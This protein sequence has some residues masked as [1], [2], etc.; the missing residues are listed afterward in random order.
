MIHYG[1]RLKAGM[2]RVGISNFVTFLENTAEYRRD[3]R[4]QEYGDERDPNMRG[5][6]IK[7]SPTTSAHKINKPMFIAQGL[8]DPRVPANESE[9]IVASARNSGVDV[10]YM[11]AKDEGH[12][13]SKKKNI[14][15]CY[16]HNWR[17]YLRFNGTSVAADGCAKRLLLQ[18]YH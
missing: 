8:N 18:T 16:L 15:R 3:L 9:Q 6:L 5:F 2:E 1:N 10:W 11:L 14:V 7:I 13:F 12:G 4:R 17:L